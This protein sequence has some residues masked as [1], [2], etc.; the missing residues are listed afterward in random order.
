MH[1]DDVAIY[2][3]NRC[4]FSCKHCVRGKATDD[5]LS[6]EMLDK[7]LLEAGRMGFSFAS[8]T[9]GEPIMHPEFARVLDVIMEHDWDF[10]FVTNGWKYQEYLEVLEPRTKNW[11]N[12]AVS[13]DG[14]TEKT[15][16]KIRKKGSF[17]KATK[18]IEVFAA[19]EK[20]VTVNCLVLDS[21]TEDVLDLIKLAKHLGA[22]NVWL[23]G[24]LP[25]PDGKAKSLPWE[26][27]REI[28]V[29]VK[30]LSRELQFRVNFASCFL[31]MED[32]AKCANMKDPQPSINPVGE[33]AFCCNTMGRGALVGSLADETFK[34]LYIKTKKVGSSLIKN[35]MQNWDKLDL[36][37]SNCVFCN[38]VLEDTI[39]PFEG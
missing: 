4:N 15:N 26:K 34:Q 27:R 23:A 24:M 6:I 38:R 18:A 10:N 35:K 25:T 32:V 16:D 5:D 30:E 21:N 39:K 33:I 11:R 14:A 17:K 29:A 13:L 37:E 2:L 3:T 36:E 20:P 8:L 31:R 19:S 9:G 22:S 28:R 7:L 12:V 1:R